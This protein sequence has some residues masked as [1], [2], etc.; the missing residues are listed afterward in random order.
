MMSSSI[1]ISPSAIGTRIS[2]IAVECFAPHVVPG[3]KDLGTVGRENGW[4]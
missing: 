3:E 2:E 4:R 1:S